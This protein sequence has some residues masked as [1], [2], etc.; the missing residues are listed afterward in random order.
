MG[1]LGAKNLSPIRID[2]RTM[3]S[4]RLRADFIRRW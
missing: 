3:L 1:A 4:L 2:P